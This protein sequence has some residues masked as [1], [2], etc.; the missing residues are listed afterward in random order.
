M[1]RYTFKYIKDGVETSSEHTF[2][3]EPTLQDTVDQMNSYNPDEILDY[4]RETE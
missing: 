1:I 2:D 3:T 4:I